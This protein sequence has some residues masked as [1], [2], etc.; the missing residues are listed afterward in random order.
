MNTKDKYDGCNPDLTPLFLAS[1][2]VSG[3]VEYYGDYVKADAFDYVSGKGYKVFLSDFLELDV[4]WV[5]EFYTDK[6][7]EP[8]SEKKYNYLRRAGVLWL[9][10]PECTGTWAE[11]SRLFSQVEEKELKEVQNISPAKSVVMS[12]DDF[13]ACWDIFLDFD[14]AIDADS[15]ID[16]ISTSSCA[17]YNITAKKVD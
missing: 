16:L 8:M 13:G 17:N 1:Q 15:F 11:D 5:G 7:K 14:N 6:P 12:I 4:L 9:H 3:W 10:H 2:M